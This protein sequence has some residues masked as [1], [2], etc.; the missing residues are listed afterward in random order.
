MQR[1]PRR[2]S[3]R[4]W[5]TKGSAQPHA[6]QLE[7]QSQDYRPHHAASNSQINR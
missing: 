3:T 6:L 1:N 7:V 2:Q 4:L 5:P